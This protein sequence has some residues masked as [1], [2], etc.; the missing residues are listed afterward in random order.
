MA[1]LNLVQGDTN[2]RVTFTV[3]YNNDSTP[4]D[5][6][7]STPYFVFAKLGNNT[8]VFKRTCSI[9]SGMAASG[10]CYY[11]WQEDDLEDAGTYSGELEIHFPDGEIQ[12]TS[13]LMSF[14]VRPQLG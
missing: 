7:G 3:T 1:L 10:E 13:T 2:P 14:E 9:A 6:T 12:T 8:Y 11:D 5:L 4:V